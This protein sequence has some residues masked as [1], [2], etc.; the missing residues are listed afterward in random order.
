MECVFRALQGP[1][2]LH[3]IWIRAASMRTPTT[4]IL[5]L[6]LLVPWSNTLKFQGTLFLTWYTEVSS[7]AVCTEYCKQSTFSGALQVPWKYTEPALHLDGGISGPTKMFYQNV[8]YNVF[9]NENTVTLFL[10]QS[11]EKN[12]RCTHEVCKQ[13]HSWGASAPLPWNFRGST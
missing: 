12:I 8:Q 10:E 5:L 6:L 11:V 2:K 9:P 4:T 13:T 7:A 3:W 1:L